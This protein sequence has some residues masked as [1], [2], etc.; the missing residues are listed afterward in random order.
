[1]EEKMIRF[2]LVAMVLELIVGNMIGQQLPCKLSRSAWKSKILTQADAVRIR[3]S[4]SLRLA[5]GLLVKKGK[6]NEKKRN[7]GRK[8]KIGIS[9]RFFSEPLNNPGKSAP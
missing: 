9:C 3:I 6:W 2:L 1:M 8:A 5:G 7:D 4:G